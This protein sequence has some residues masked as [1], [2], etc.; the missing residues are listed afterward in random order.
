MIN[1]M[2]WSQTPCILQSLEMMSSS[3]LNTITP[4]QLMIEFCILKDEYRDLKGAMSRSATIPFAQQLQALMMNTSSASTL[5]A[6]DSQQQLV[7]ALFP[8]DEATAKNIVRFLSVLKMF[9]EK[10]HELNKIAVTQWKSEQL[11]LSFMMYTANK[12][13]SRFDGNQDVSNTQHDVATS[14]TMWLFIHFLRRFCIE[15]K[16]NGIELNDF[17]RENTENGSKM[18]VFGEALADRVC[19]HFKFDVV[20]FGSEMEMLSVWFIEELRRFK[21]HPVLLEECS[22]EDIVTLLTFEGVDD[23]K[24]DDSDREPV[25]GVFS[26]F[27]KLNEDDLESLEQIGDWKSKIVDWVQTEEVDGKEMTENSNEEMAAELSSV[28]SQNVSTGSK[29]KMLKRALKTQ[30]LSILNLCKNMNIYF[31]FE[32]VAIQKEALQGKAV[33]AQ[34][35]AVV[36]NVRSIL[37]QELWVEGDVPMTPIFKMNATDFWCVVGQWIKCDIDY[38]RKLNELQRLFK[39]YG[40]SGAILHSMCFQEKNELQLI[41][42]I[43]TKNMAQHLTVDTMKVIM[44]SLSRWLTSAD[45]RDV[46]LASSNDVAQR[47]MEFPVRKL[48]NAICVEPV[49]DGKKFVESPHVFSLLAQKTTGWLSSECKLLSQSMTRK[50]S[51][52]KNQILEKVRNAAS[53][54]RKIEEFQK[55]SV[56]NKL[57]EG[58]RTDCDLEAVHYNLRVNAVVYPVFRKF[59]QKLMNNMMKHQD[60][61]GVHEVE[62]VAAFFDILSS[63]MIV[64]VDRDERKGQMPWICLF[65]GNQNVH[66]V[67]GYKLVTDISIC[68]LCGFAQSES[69]TMALKGVEMPF[70]RGNNG[71]NIPIERKENVEDVIRSEY[72]ALIDEMAAGKEADLHCALQKDHNLCPTLRGCAQ[73]LM[74]QRRYFMNIEDKGSKRIFTKND[75][76]EVVSFEKYEEMVID[77]VKEVMSKK[78]DKK[79]SVMESVA[80]LLDNESS[81]I[82]KFQEYFCRNGKRKEYLK[83]LKDNTPMNGGQAAKLFKIVAAKLEE[84]VVAEM[85]QLYEKW[86]HNLKLSHAMHVREHLEEY[87]LKSATEPRKQVIFSFFQNVLHYDDSVRTKT[88]CLECKQK[89]IENRSFT[90]DDSANELVHCELDKVHLLLCHDGEIPDTED[91]Q[92]QKTENSNDEKEDG[93]HDDDG[94]GDG[95]EAKE[96]VGTE[97]KRKL[98]KYVTGDKV[99]SYGFGINHNY[100]HLSPRFPSIRDELH[101]N[102]P[103]PQFLNILKKAIETVRVKLGTESSAMT[104]KEYSVKHGILRNEP[105]TMRHV[106]SLLSYTDLTNFCREFRNTFRTKSEKEDMAKVSERHEEFYHFGRALFEIADHFGETMG[107]KVRVYHGLSI[108]MCFGSFSEYFNAP[109]S[110]TTS[111]SVGTYFFPSILRT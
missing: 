25:V 60:L 2:E 62:F 65:C 72:D 95:D 48:K 88:L 79:E 6:D 11:A 56:T 55:E 16:M 59:V 103:G 27:E 34:K 8:D 101:F 53:S 87:H 61:V 38:N 66:K 68:S 39:K 18:K 90:L 84:L 92:E 67:I 36:N 64:H 108:K 44:E 73:M 37:D 1:S 10:Q 80:K 100:I 57:I 15:T 3:V 74:E 94:D 70:Q 104:A 12:V 111:K 82:R 50:V 23:G 40:I 69:I 46:K 109:T 93:D 110:T 99:T 13:M 97:S 9:I 78:P 42:N 26:D 63:A 30:C 76:T 49:V 29:R 107:P 77:A 71:A 102:N 17:W 20:P 19:S 81:E 58:L 4:I 83:L 86:L 89:K 33:D 24:E 35:E 41:E 32:A 96:E 7:M 22:V 75:L 28:L 21:K 43:L 105:I 51:L 52:S 31:I 54:Q 91:E 14:D 47:I 98:W 85:P 45:A 5:T 106:F